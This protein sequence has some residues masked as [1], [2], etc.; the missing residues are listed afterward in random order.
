M[1]SQAYTYVANLADPTHIPADGILSRTL[2]KDERVRAIL[3]GFAAGE[4]LSEHTAS[5]P[6]ILH[7]VQGEARLTLGDETMEAGAGAWAHMPPGLPHS[8]F[9]RTPLVMLLLMFP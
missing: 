3:F 9:A 1:M 2:Y 4:E 8:V 5:M 6:A 7:I